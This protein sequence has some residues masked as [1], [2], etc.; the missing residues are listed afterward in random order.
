MGH[1]SCRNGRCDCAPG[2]TYFDC[3]LRELTPLPSPSSVPSLPLASRTDASLLTP[4]PALPCLLTSRFCLCIQEPA[5]ETALASVYASTAPAGAA[6][7]SVAVTAQNTAAQMTVQAVVS[8]CRRG[9]GVCANA[10]LAL[11]APTAASV[12]VRTSVR[13]MVRARRLRERHLRRRL[14]GRLLVCVSWASR[15]LTA[16]SKP[17]LTIADGKV[18]ATTARATASQDLAVVRVHFSRAPATAVAMADASMAAASAPQGGEAQTVARACAQRTAVATAI[19]DR[20]TSAFVT[21]TGLVTTARLGHAARIALTVVGAY[22]AR[23]TVSQGSTAHGATYAIVPVT[24]LSRASVMKG[25]VAATLAFLASTARCRCARAGALPT[26]AVLAPHATATKGSLATTARV[27]SAQQT[28]MG[29]AS[30]QMARASVSRDTQ[31]AIVASAHAQTTVQT[32][33]SARISTASAIRSLQACTFVWGWEDAG[34]ES[35]QEVA[36]LSLSCPPLLH[37]RHQRHWPAHNTAWN[38]HRPSGHADNNPA[39]APTSVSSPVPAQRANAHPVSHH[40]PTHHYATRLMPHATHHSHPPV[41]GPDCALRVCGPKCTQHGYCDDGTCFCDVGFTG[42]ECSELICPHGC[43]HQ[44]DCEE[45]ICFCHA[46]FSGLDCSVRGCADGCNGNGV[47]TNGACVCYEGFGGV[48]CQEAMCAAGCSERGK[49]YN[50]SCH[51]TPG[52]S[53]LDCS[54][55]LCPKACSPRPPPHAH[56]FSQHT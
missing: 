15:V 55:S 11:Q 53:G 13:V 32:T 33:A 19:A 20:A 45:G 10:I 54:A 8:A 7:D 24:A 6:T 46:G 31:G 36:G 38:H 12:P 40:H 22:M 25:N 47:C 5:P 9:R 39:T 27:R 2:Y 50:G 35:G 1:G 17:A 37:P 49:C 56:Q 3:S 18:T 43:N 14:H 16:R 26:A 29:L 48:D 51:C 4:R 28:A 42:S 41:P 30:A 21:R 34:V 23:A 44:G 52:F